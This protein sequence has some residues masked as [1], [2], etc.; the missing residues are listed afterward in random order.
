MNR[1]SVLFGEKIAKG[2]ER[3]GE[4]LFAFPSPQFSARPKACSQA[5]IYMYHQLGFKD[6]AYLRP[7]S[8]TEYVTSENITGTASSQRLIISPP[9]LTDST[10][11]LENNIFK[12]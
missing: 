6:T 7:Q 3:G 2:K 9:D 10:V 8:M 12:W 11:V 5:T 1:L 4:S